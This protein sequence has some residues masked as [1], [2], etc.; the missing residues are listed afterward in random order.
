MH[1]MHYAGFWIRFVAYILD[2]AAYWMCL[3]IISTFIGG[4]LAELFKLGFVDYEQVMNFIV[5]WSW[6][7]TILTRWLYYAIQYASPYQATF[8]MRFVGLQVVDYQYERISFKRA[9]GRFLAN[10]LS[11]ISIS[12][13]YVMIAFTKKKQGL[14]DIVARTYVVHKKYKLR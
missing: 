1:D 11:I 12:I 4:F 13:G 7:L 8:G 2:L 5:I 9:S 14:H 6:P 3:V 10:L